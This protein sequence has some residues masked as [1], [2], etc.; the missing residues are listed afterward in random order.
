MTVLPRVAPVAGTTAEFTVAG[1]SLFAAGTTVK[2]TLRRESVGIILTVKVN[3]P[4]KLVCLAYH[5]GLTIALL[6]FSLLQVEQ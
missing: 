3:F 6:S 5:K 2:R 1:M 4:V